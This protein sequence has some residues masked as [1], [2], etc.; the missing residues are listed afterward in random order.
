MK[1]VIPFLLAGMMLISVTGCGLLESSEV[2]KA[3]KQGMQA[4]EDGA[5]TEA[6]EAFDEA[7]DLGSKRDKTEDLYEMLKDFTAAQE[8]YNSQNYRE[9]EHYLDELDDDYK[10]YD[11]FRKDVRELKKLVDGAIDEQNAAN[12][13]A[14]EKAASDAAQAAADAKAVAAQAQQRPP[15]TAYGNGYLFPSDTQYL[16]V[17]YLNTL[18]KHTIDLIRNEIYARHGYIFQTAEFAN[19]FN[20]QSWYVPSVPA[21]S[22]NTGVFNAVENANLSLLIQYQGL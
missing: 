11:S 8:A 6:I 15:V 19:Y 17:D 22:F 10:N 3:T 20:A 9:A 12:I 21:A 2:R 1:K 16:T 18:D 13:A 7:L 14:A 5:Y 4:L